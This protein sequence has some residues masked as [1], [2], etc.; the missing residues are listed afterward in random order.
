MSGDIYHWNWNSSFSDNRNRHG[1]WTGHGDPHRNWHG[2][3]SFH[4][5]R[6][7]N[8]NTHGLGHTHWYSD[9]LGTTAAAPTA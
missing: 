9:D 4:G 5:N 1:I 2:Y 6:N 8:W 7:P 3:P